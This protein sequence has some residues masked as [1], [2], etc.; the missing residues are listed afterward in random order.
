MNSLNIRKM[1]NDDLSHADIRIITQKMTEENSKYGLGTVLLWFIQKALPNKVITIYEAFQLM[2]ISDRLQHSGKIQSYF[3]FD[4]IQS[5]NMALL[6][7]LFNEK[8]LYKSFFEDTISRKNSYY[9]ELKKDND[10]KMPKGSHYILDDLGGFLSGDIEHME[11]LS[12]V[13]EH[14]HRN[15]RKDDPYHYSVFPY[16]NF[17]YEDELL[18][19]LRGEIKYYEIDKS[20][21]HEVCDMMTAIELRAIELK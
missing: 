9:A 10:G 8:A 16:D 5:M 14:T 20:I 4:I 13:R 19:V 7:E 2:E 12:Y 1:I 3:S 17:A 6:A 21:S 18:K 15:S 11:K